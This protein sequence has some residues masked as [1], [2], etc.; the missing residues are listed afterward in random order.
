MTVH[1]PM[2]QAPLLSILV[3]AYAYRDGLERILTALS[4]LPAEIEMLIF[5]DSLDDDLRSVVHAFEAQM[6]SLRYQHN[7]S[8]RGSPLGAGANWNALLDAARGEYCILMHHDE[9]PLED[10]F[11]S[12]LQIVLTT[13]PRPDVVMLDLLLVD[14][15]LRP[16]RRHVPAWL[17]QVVPRRVPGYL[18]RRNVI[19][20]TATIVVRREITPRFDTTLRWLID[21]EFYVR[22]CRAGLRWKIEP[23]IQIGSIQ[24]SAGTITSELTNQ[25]PTIDAAERESLIIR[26]PRDRL[27]LD[28]ERGRLIRFFESFLWLSMRMVHFA[29]SSLSMRM[30]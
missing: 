13:M 7:L 23:D 16:L 5:D 21:V 8:D 9:V 20:P 29:M 22:L 28:T 19:G 10:T 6:P 11:I 26:Y 25:L 1:R 3:P 4:P 2:K 18:F 12:T 27:W 14:E 24:R 30:R 17:R 15:A